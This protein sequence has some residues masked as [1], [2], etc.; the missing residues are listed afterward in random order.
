M[1][2]PASAAGPKEKEVK[3]RPH[4]RRP[5]PTRLADY[6]F[7]GTLRAGLLAAAPPASR[8][9]RPA[10]AHSPLSRVPSSPVTAT[11]FEPIDP[12]ALTTPQAA[13]LGLSTLYALPGA[14]VAAGARGAAAFDQQTLEELAVYPPQRTHLWDLGR[15]RSRASP[16]SLGSQG[17]AAHAPR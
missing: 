6:L 16:R 13:S 3:V 9:A 4:R 14:L 12:H 5:L 2:P 11:G 1:E 7:R 17:R 8:R 15:P 10:S